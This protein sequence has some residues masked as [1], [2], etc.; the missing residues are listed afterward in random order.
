MTVLLWGM[1]LALVIP[2]A[3]ACRQQDVWHRL[4]AFS[5]IASKVAL[6]ILVVSVVRSDW[7]LG[8]VGVIVLS[9]GNAGMLLL[10][11]L[12]REER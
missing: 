9:A 1:V 3:V 6:I 2:I 8:L 4:A 12:L 7:M 10:A 5:S 11:N